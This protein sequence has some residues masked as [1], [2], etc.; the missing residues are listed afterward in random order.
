MSDRSSSLLRSAFYEAFFVVLGVIL[1]LAANEWRQN[2]IQQARADGALEAVRAELR[3]D[4]ELLRTSLGYHEEKMGALWGML[5]SGA[6]PEGAGFFD[7]GFVSPAQVQLTAWQTA[8]TTGLVESFALDDVLKLSELYGKLER[9]EA[10]ALSIGQTI[11]AVMLDEGIDGMTARWR[12]LMAIQGTF[13]YR[14]KELTGALEGYLSA[15]D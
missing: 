4:L 13:V 3:L 12:N 7:R 9:Y 6:E 2:Q 11:Y 15:D 8:K 14:E 1:A 10:Q 5:Q